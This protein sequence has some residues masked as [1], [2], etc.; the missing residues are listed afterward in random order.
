MA[1]GDLQGLVDALAEDLGRPVG[2][3][4]RHFRAVV[5]SSH[6]DGVDPVRVASILQRE[7]PREVTAWLESL[8]IQDAEQPVRVP[9]NRGFD[10][11][12][13]VCVP[14]RFDGTLLGYLWLIDEPEP[15]GDAELAES[16]RYATDIGV[17]LYRVRRLEHDDRERERELLEQLVGRRPGADPA[18]A[19]EE[20]LREGF[21]ATAGSYAVIVAQA[22]DAEGRRAPDEVR[23]RL[24]AA[25]EHVRRA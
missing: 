19:A 21:L 22:F 20:L 18:G 6:V 2:V 13:R 7:A 10:M 11:A 12:A 5:Y 14:I 16:L 4:D 23:V 24:A 8:G 3:D 17:A 9:A 1:I 15:L 25:A